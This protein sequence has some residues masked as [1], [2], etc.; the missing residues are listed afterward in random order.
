VTG[1]FDPAEMELNE[2]SGKIVGAAIK[3]HSGLGPG[4]LE[5][6]YRACLRHELS[7]QGLRTDVEA[8]LPLTYAA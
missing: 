4:L 5:S 6:A 1:L 3:V 2:I 7:R 8:V